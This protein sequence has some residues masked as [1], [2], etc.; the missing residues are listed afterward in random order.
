[1]TSI[2]TLQAMIKVQVQNILE[3]FYFFGKLQKEEMAIHWDIDLL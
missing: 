1:M 3:K 2:T